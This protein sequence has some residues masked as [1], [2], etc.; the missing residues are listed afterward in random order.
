CDRCV[1]SI[2]IYS[3]KSDSFMPRCGAGTDYYDEPKSCRGARQVAGRKRLQSELK[4]RARDPA[5][6]RET[7]SSFAPSIQ[8]AIRDSA[9]SD[10]AASRNR[11]PQ[12]IAVSFLKIRG[13]AGPACSTLRSG[14]RNALPDRTGHKKRAESDGAS[15]SFLQSDVLWGQEF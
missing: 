14:T 4:S 10:R 15:D 6:A 2:S 8:S 7:R 13:H 3:A 12:R 11:A 1:R 5:F 9:D